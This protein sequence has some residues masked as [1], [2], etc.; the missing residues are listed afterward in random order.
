M[1]YIWKLETAF[2]KDVVDSFPEPKPASTTVSTVIRTLVQ[3]EVVGFKRYGPANQYFPLVSKK[4]Y[5]KAFFKGMVS[6]YFNNSYQTFASFFAK[7]E[8]LS[9][10]ELEEL[11]QLVEKQIEAKQKQETN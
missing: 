5:R 7:S 1:Q 8:D 9:I 6:R 3:K 10:S 4:D 11:K 2:L